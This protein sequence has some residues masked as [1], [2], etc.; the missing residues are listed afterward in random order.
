VNEPQTLPLIDGVVWKQVCD[1]KVGDEVRNV[2]IVVKSTPSASFGRTL[3]RFGLHFGAW[4]DVSD[5]WVPV[6]V[7]P[8]VYEQTRRTTDP[9]VAQRWRDWWE[10]QGQGLTTDVSLG[11]VVELGDDQ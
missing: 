6:L 5:A 10:A 4:A 7:K 9:A 1:L 11:E 2:G 8:V 3:I